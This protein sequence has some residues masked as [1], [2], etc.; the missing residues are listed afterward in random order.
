MRG[1][2]PFLVRDAWRDGLVSEQAGGAEE[3][4]VSHERKHGVPIVPAAIKDQRGA[5]QDEGA[6]HE[7]VVM[8]VLGRQL[9]DDIGDRRVAR[10]RIERTGNYGQYKDEDGKTRH[11]HKSFFSR[12]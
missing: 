6:G 5:Q 7:P 11:S 12:I 2:H 1:V 9:A 3:E 10:S 4:T 8:R